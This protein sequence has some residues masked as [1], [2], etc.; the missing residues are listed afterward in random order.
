M[1]NAL[2]GAGAQLNAGTLQQQLNQSALNV[3]YQQYQQ[4]QAY[5]YQQAQWL[6]NTSLGLGQGM[7]GSSSTTQ[8]GPDGTSQALGNII[9]IAG[10]A[11]SIFSC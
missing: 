8:P 11:A 10:T 2:T 7:G 4:Q 1:N 3:P 9:G 6:A 5:P